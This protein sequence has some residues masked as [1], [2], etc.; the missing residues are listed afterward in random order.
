MVVT[1]SSLQQLLLQ[2]AVVA[3]GRG[4]LQGREGRTTIGYSPDTQQQ[5]VAVHKIELSTQITHTYTAA[6][7]GLVPFGIG[8]H[9]YTNVSPTQAEPT[10]L[11]VLGPRA[12]GNNNSKLGQTC[13]QSHAC[14]QRLRSRTRRTRSTATIISLTD[15]VAPSRQSRWNREGSKSEPE[16]D[17]SIAAHFLHFLHLLLLLWKIPIY[18]GR[19]SEDSCIFPVTTYRKA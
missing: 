4:K 8:R 6:S 14:P 2:L 16:L 3:I 11:L 18:C 10:T 15:A 19:F 7:A 17:L 12:T 9:R 13:C 5:S 1:T